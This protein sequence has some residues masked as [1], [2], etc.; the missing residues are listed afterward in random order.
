MR[1]S[2]AVAVE[3]FKKD[4]YSVLIGDDD[5]TVISQLQQEVNSGIEKWSDINHATCTMAKALYEGRG[6]DFGPRNDKL[7][8]KVKK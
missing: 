2:G 8:D 6:Q 3:L 1:L 4:H 7:T 5:S